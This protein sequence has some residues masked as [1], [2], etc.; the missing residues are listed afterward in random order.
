MPTIF[1]L[2]KTKDSEK[3]TLEKVVKILNKAK[4]GNLLV[5]EEYTTLK[6]LLNGSLVGSSKLL[7][8]I[9][10]EKYAIWDSR[11]HRY[12]RETTNRGTF[13]YDVGDVVNYEKYL[14]L[15]LEITKY[16]KFDKLYSPI[17]D[18]IY[19]K[20]KYKITKFRAIELLMFKNGKK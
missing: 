4:K 9:N 5:Y 15:L 12:L 18:L 2:K 11:V 6:E 3:D 10:P 14:K 13:S 17:N 20:Y 1:E 16:S 8:F 7:H 19:S